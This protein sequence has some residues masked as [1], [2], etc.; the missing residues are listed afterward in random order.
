MEFNPGLIEDPRPQALKDKDYSHKEVAPMA[1]LLK[2]DRDISGAP[3]Y[4]H[5]DQD[6]SGSCVAQSGAK[7]LEVLRKE[8]ISAHPIYSRR[9][10]RPNAGMWLQDAGN[11]IRNMGT[12]T[13]VLD[14]SQML[15][16]GKMNLPVTVDTPIKSYLYAFPSYKNIDEIAQAIEVYGEC[17]VTIYANGTEYNNAYKPVAIPNA[18]LNVA[19]CLCATYYF[20]DEN[21]EK[22]LVIDESWQSTKTRV[23][24]ETYFKIRGT[25]AMY[26]IPPTDAPV[27]SKP[28]YKFS[29]PL[30]FGQSSY[31]IKEL[32][33]ILKYEN[34]FPLNIPSTAYFG[35]IT[36]K[37]VLIWQ[38]KHQVA[39]DSELDPLQG[40]RVGP[41]TIAKLNELYS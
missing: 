25:G 11:I 37:A 20:T 9:T 31:G 6:G 28:H 33:D 22:C 26:L 32:Q 15:D 40:R 38:K 41:K 18:E 7:A 2:W 3:K 34:I 29:V 4:S 12:T 5:R 21:G 16:E 30:L 19:H 17:F 14:P 27:P 13:E 23:F 24:T 35:N 8:V 39:P 36:S 10:N 1:V